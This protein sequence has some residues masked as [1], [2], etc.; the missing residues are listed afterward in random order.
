MGCVGKRVE[1]VS[2]TESVIYR[3]G[4]VILRMHTRGQFSGVQ[5]MISLLQGSYVSVVPNIYS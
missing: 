3:R 2:R 4:R 5:Y 1:V